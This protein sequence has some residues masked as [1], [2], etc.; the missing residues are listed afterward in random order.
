MGII[1]W[2]ILGGLAGWAAGA[3]SGRGSSGLLG[4]IVL[5]IIG[6]MFGGWIFSL[7]GGEGI[8]G[9]NV[10]SFFVAVVGAIIFSAIWSALTGSRRR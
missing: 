4:N 8:T 2:I 3:L 6:G 9:F 10:W 7:L 1:A 5:G